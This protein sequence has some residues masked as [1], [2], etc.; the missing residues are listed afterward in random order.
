M[1]QLQKFWRSGADVIAEK[2]GIKVAIQCKLYNNPVGNDSVQQVLAGKVFYGAQF[3]AV[4]SNSEFTKS[5]KQIAEIS[6]VLLL[7]HEQVGKLNDLID[8]R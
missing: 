1:P 7:H 6:N 4:V 2:D 8:K 5:A 3:A